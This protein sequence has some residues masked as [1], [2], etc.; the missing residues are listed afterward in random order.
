MLST[1]K[2]FYEIEWPKHILDSKKYKNRN[3]E[4]IETFNLIA[5]REGNEYSS[6][7]QTTLVFESEHELEIPVSFNIFKKDFLKITQ[8]NTW[9]VEFAINIILQR[10]DFMNAIFENNPEI[11]QDLLKL[12]EKQKTE[13]I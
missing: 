9:Y 5:I 8:K 11:Y 10:A 12:I 7:F 3:K 1:S 2:Q 13:V 4:K 6:V